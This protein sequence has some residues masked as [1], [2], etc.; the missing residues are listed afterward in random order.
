MRFFSH[1]GAGTRYGRVAHIFAALLV[2]LVVVASLVCISAAT[3]VLGEPCAGEHVSPALCDG[4]MAF[5][6]TVVGKAASAAPIFVVMLLALAGF[7]ASYAVRRFAGD[8]GMIRLRP[9]VS[10]IALPQ[11][12]NPLVELFA[13]GILNPK[14]Y[15]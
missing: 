10:G 5:H 8:V 9:R 12:A 3:P 15:G 2:G 14:V 13:S 11:P 1:F 7:F 4:A 6:S